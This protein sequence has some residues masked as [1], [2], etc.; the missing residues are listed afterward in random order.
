MM[1]QNRSLTPKRLIRPGMR[2]GLLR[3]QATEAIILWACYDGDRLEEGSLEDFSQLPKVPKSQCLWLDII[4][5]PGKQGLAALEK[6]YGV[7]R[8]VLEDVQNAG[9]MPKYEEFDNHSFSVFQLPASE[10]DPEQFTQL[11]LLCSENLVISIHP[12]VGLFE[13]VRK[14]LN[15]NRGV[16]RTAGEEYLLYALVDLAVDLGFPLV[17]EYTESL[18]NFEERVEAAQADLSRDIYALRRQLSALLRHAQRQRD[19]VRKLV[20]QDRL[21]SDS[22]NAVYWRDCLDHAERYADNLSYL[23]E[24]AADLLS[25]HLALVSHRMNDVM[26][27]LTIMSSVF[28]PLSFLVGLYGMNFDT[29]SPYNLP[30]LGWKF[31]YLFVWCVMLCLVSGLLYFFRRKGWI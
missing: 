19:L 30:E 10:A 14:R 8:L 6:A 7:H 27:V 13:P 17:N 26:K 18:L 25:T 28:I 29:S 31:G 3:E 11:N 21:E 12:R 1:A 22:R 16:I 5:V 15:A 2:P 4:G 9:Q 20:E 23:R 24:N